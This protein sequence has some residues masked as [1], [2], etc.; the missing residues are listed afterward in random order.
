LHKWF[1][2]TVQIPHPQ[3]IISFAISHPIRTPFDNYYYPI[4]TNLQGQTTPDVAPDLT[5]ASL[6]AQ[7]TFAKDNDHRMGGCRPL[8]ANMS[9]A[10]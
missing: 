8:H 3:K 4:R 6:H 1:A 5:T 2:H 7:V 10:G 9:L